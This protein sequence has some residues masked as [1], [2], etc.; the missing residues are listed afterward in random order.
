MIFIVDPALYL[1]VLAYSMFRSLSKS[2]IFPIY[3][4]NIS[5]ASW[6]SF[7][8]LVPSASATSKL[9][10]ILAVT[11]RSCMYAKGLPTQLHVPVMC[12]LRSS[13]CSEEGRKLTRPEWLEHF[14][15]MRQRILFR[16]TPSFGDELCW[17]LEISGIYQ[18]E[19]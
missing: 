4:T 5:R 6:N 3:K 11:I 19:F 7:S 9:R 18:A 16:L 8:S 17:V 1:H 2:S 10:I 14:L 13:P 12:K 15:F